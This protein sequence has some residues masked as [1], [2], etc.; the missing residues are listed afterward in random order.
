MLHIK[1][2]DMG[3]FDLFKKAEIEITPVKQPVPA[4]KS[5]V[6]AGFKPA[7]WVIRQGYDKV[8][9]H[10]D[11][12][13]SI[14]EALYRPYQTAI[15]SGDPRKEEQSVIRH[16][17]HKEWKWHE[18]EKW[19]VEFRKLQEW[20]AMWKGILSPG[21]RDKEIT[22]VDQQALCKLLA[23][24]LSATIMTLV[25][26][27]QG[28]EAEECGVYRYKW[29]ASVGD[30]RSLIEKKLSDKFNRGEITELPPFFPGCLCRLV[31]DRIR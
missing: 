6:D 9:Q 8:M 11:V 29:G 13:D 10:I 20:P 3:F 16:L 2:P 18:F 28:L 21:E 14:K 23:Q 7:K 25:H 19:A 31:H 5:A 4:I 24:H 15:R 22:I 26:Y 27:H 12:A 1:G 17:A 30:S